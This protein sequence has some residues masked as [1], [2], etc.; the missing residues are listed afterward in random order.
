[1]KVLACHSLG[2]FFRIKSYNYFKRYKSIWHDL[3]AVLNDFTC[4]MRGFEPLVW[5]LRACHSCLFLSLSEDVHLLSTWGGHHKA[6]PLWY[7]HNVCPVSHLYRLHETTT[8][9]REHNICNLVTFINFCILIYI[10]N[11]GNAKA[12]KCLRASHFSYIAP[13]HPW[14]K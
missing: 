13:L 6:G 12:L 2:H 11:N 7:A 14:A 8:C 10:T 3:A 4:W 9:Y 5:N 1:M